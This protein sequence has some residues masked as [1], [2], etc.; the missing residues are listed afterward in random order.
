M[1]GLVAGPG[2]EPPGGGEF[3]KICTKFLKKIAE[4]ELF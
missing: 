2:A 4:Y 1:A 3:W